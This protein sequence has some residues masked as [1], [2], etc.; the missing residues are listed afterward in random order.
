[1][2]KI[3]LRSLPLTLFVAVIG[4][5]ST[6]PAAA[7]SVSELM[8]RDCDVLWEIRNLEYFKAGYCFKSARG[9]RAFGNA[10]CHR[11]ESQARRAMGASNRRYVDRVRQAERRKGC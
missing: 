2:L 11:N 10:N 7:Q 6:P 3:V 8:E 1:M 5:L 4:T 9:K